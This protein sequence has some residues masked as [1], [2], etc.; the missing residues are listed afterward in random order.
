MSEEM[1]EQP[2]EEFGEPHVR[3]LLTFADSEADL[4]GEPRPTE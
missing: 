3:Q 4:A 1:I 2:N